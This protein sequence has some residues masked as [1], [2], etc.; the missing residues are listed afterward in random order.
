[1]DPLQLQ[2]HSGFPLRSCLYSL[3]LIFFSFLLELPLTF[4]PTTLL[5]LLCMVI[6]DV[7]IV[8]SSGYFSLLLSH[9]SLQCLILETLSSSG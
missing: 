1:M 4:A 9:T 2:L 6:G 3:S 5:K 8:K 7:H